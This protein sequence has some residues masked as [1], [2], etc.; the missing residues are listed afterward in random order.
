MQ[1]LSYG[2]HRAAMFGRADR[3]ASAQPLNQ[4]PQAGAATA[5]AGQPPAKQ[6]QPNRQ[7]RRSPPQQQPAQEAAGSDRADRSASQGFITATPE[8]NAIPR[9]CR[10]TRQEDDAQLD[11]LAK[12]GGFAS[13]TTTRP[14]RPTFRW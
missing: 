11:A 10:P 8:I 3:A 14:F 4:G 12:K 5:K 1:T 9:S 2:G 6:A 13:L 7:S